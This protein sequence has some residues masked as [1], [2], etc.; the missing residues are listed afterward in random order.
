LLQV[1]SINRVK[2]PYTLLRALKLVHT[3]QPDVYLDWVGEDTLGGE[4]QRLAAELGLANQVVFHDFQPTEVVRTLAQQAHLYVQ[5]S[6]HE[7]QG[8]SVLE[9]AAAGI[10]TVGTAVGVVA[11][12]APTAALAVSPGDPSALAD[13]ILQLLHH[14]AQREAL[15]Q[16]AQTWAR[17][18]DADWTATEYEALYEAIGTEKRMSIQT[19]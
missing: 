12:M 16:A 8:V 5:S 19:R 1:A 10:P 14:P 15:G 3:S 13:G 7:G 18:Y 17:T 6:L 2:D 11:E 9:A 4:I